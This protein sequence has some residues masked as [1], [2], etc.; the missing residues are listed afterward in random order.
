MYTFILHACVGV[1]KTAIIRRYTSGEFTPG[2]KLT[3]GVDFAVKKVMSYMHTFIH[4]YIHRRMHRYMHSYVYVHSIR[5]CMYCMYAWMYSVIIHK[6]I[7]TDMRT[8]HMHIHKFIHMCIQVQRDESS[9]TLQLWD[10]AGHERF[11]HMTHVYYKVITIHHNSASYIHSVLCSMQSPPLSFLI[12]FAKQPLNLFS[13]SVC[14]VC[15][16][17]YALCVCIVCMNESM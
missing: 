8:H 9:I 12:L 1:G 6:S 13:R 16:Y 10:I 2:Y 3:I 5:M 4:T 11:G 14:F 7:H 17:V 15:M